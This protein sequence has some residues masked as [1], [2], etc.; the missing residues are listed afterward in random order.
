[1]GRG[2]EHGLDIVLVAQRCGAHTLAAALLRGVL[3]DGHALDVAAVREREHALLL[4]DEVLDVDVVLDVL[5]LGLARVAVLVA[6]GDEL[7]AQHALDLFGVGEQLAEVGDALLELVIFVLQLLALETLQGLEAH[8]ED[9][10]RLHLGETEALHEVFL[11]VII[12]LADDADDLVDVLLGDEQTLKQMCALERFLEVELRAPDDDLLLEGEILVEDVPQGQDLRLRL[13]VDQREHIHGERGLHL[14]LGEE[15]VEHDLRVGVLLELDDDAHAVAVGLV[16]QAGDAVE[17]LVAHLLGDVLDELALV[18]L[19][20][21]LGHDD[22]D[23]V[24]SPRLGLGAGA[25]DDAAAAGGVGRA[26][27]AAADDDAPGREVRARD[28]LHEIAERG[29]R[30]FEH[31]HAGVDDL[32]QVVRR[33]IRRHADGDARAAVDEQVR[34]AARQHARLAAGL[35]KVRVPVHGVL[36]DVAQHFVGD[37]RQA[38][39][40]VSVGGRGVAVD[41]AEVAVTVDEHIAH[42]EILRQ[43]H[44]RVI[45][46]RVAV[47]MIPAEHVADAGG[48]FFEGLVRGQVVL[49]HGVEDTP[50]HGLETV[51]HIRQRTSDDDGHG[52]LDVRGLHLMD[53][54]ALN[55]LLVGIEDVLPFIVLG[56]GCTPP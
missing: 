38:R 23:A 19:I 31:A 29:V 28:V 6:D 5:D 49:V 12:A 42:G 32:G 10:L 56:H 3:V 35:V 44:H 27:A 45:H 40:G 13:V 9:G 47:R 14:R 15:A 54:L 55:D 25:H 17:L 11:G 43:T 1:M 33:D 48:G 7:V 51:A 46:G 20:R 41:R 22:A 4:L 50:V 8:I 21:Q 37:L 52:I 36:V 53:E 39:L 18:D 2:G 26:D 30:I 34:E 16:A 24:V